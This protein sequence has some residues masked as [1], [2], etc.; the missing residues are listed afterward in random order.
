MNTISI[1][2]GDFYETTIS[3]KNYGTF[4]ATMKAITMSTLT[5]AQQKYL[6]YTVT[7]DGTTYSAS[8]SG[9]SSALATNAAK[10]VKIRLEYL[11]PT[12]SADLP[13]TDVDVTISGRLDY[14]QAQ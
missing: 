2:P 6:T 7:Y 1:K 8:Q 5:A 11:Q 3:A 13:Q 4:N 12:D 9:L 14:E 10:D